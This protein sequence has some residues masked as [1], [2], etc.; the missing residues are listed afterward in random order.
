VGHVDPHRRFVL[1]AGVEP[2]DRGASQPGPHRHTKTNASQEQLYEYGR[3]YLA[4]T[5]EAKKMHADGA[6]PAELRAF[7]DKND[8]PVNG[9]PSFVR[10]A[11]ANQTPEERQA[12]IRRR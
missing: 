6:S 2:E 9:L 4:F 5:Q 8:V 7:Q 12:S 3:K 10:I 1:P 11:W